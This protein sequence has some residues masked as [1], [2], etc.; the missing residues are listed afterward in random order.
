[1]A[2]VKQTLHAWANIRCMHRPKRPASC[3]E[4]HMF[5]SMASLIVPF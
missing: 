4:L 2:A 5:V 1:M 3:K